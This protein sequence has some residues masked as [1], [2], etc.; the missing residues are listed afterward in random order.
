MINC[1]QP[2]LARA[3]IFGVT[4]RPEL[5]PQEFAAL[6]VERL[7]HLFNMRKNS[8]AVMPDLGLRE[9]MNRLQN[10]REMGRRAALSEIESQICR[11]DSRV[12]KANVKV[13]S[14]NINLNLNESLVIS[15]LLES[16]PRRLFVQAKTPLS[17]PVQFLI[18][19]SGLI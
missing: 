17:V 4:P 10:A 6:V 14:G 15:L 12:E 5:G 8:S 7:S 3:D 1:E 2:L 13:V 9:T 19:N 11:F 16:S 18:I